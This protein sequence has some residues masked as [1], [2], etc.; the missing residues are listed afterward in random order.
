[1]RRRNDTGSG[2]MGIICILGIPLYLLMEHPLLFWLVF[3]PLAII[4]V[5]SVVQW[6]KTG[7]LGFQHAF[8]AILALVFM[9]VVAMIAPSCNPC[10][11]EDMVERYHFVAYN[12]SGNNSVREY[13]RDCGEA[14][15]LTNI[16]DTPEDQSYLEAIREHSDGSAIVPGEYYTV[17]V[18]VTLRDI[19]ADCTRLGCKVENNDFIVIFDVD[20][21][22]EF[23]EVVSLIEKGDE[24]TFRG[25]FYD[26][27][28]GF[29]DA[30]LI[31]D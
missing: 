22:E 16:G 3:L 10:K 2:L 7:G 26:E 19:E 18:I 5:I 21:R 20:F 9:T 17:T 24:I 31:T 15:P 1:M 6:F 4:F 29:K 23:E 12:V 28:C 11:H 30:E 8:R 27:G 14:F 25:R 13:C